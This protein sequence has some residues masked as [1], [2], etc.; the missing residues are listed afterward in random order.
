MK[1]SPR[2]TEIIELL[3]RGFSDKEM[4]VKCNISART[5]QT[6]VTRI[7]LKLNARNRTHAVAKYIGTIGCFG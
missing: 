7:G 4:A 5:I 3:A 1:L 6:H 2:E